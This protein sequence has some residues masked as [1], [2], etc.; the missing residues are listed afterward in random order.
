MKIK[1]FLKPTK[2]KLVILLIL[3]F[4]TF[5]IPKPGHI[6]NLDGV[7]QEVRDIGFGYPEV[8]FGWRISGDLMFGEFFFVALIVDLA[9]GYLIACLLVY[10]FNKSKK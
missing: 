3:L 8:F 2:S 10:I 1:S 7:I 9:V 6:E 5:F 4:L